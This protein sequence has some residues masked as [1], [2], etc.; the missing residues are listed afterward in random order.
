MSAPPSQPQRPT[1]DDPEA[2]RTYWKA[3]GMPWRMEPEISGIRKDDLEARRQGVRPDIER[4]LCVQRR[5]TKL[6]RADVEWLLETHESGGMRGPVDWT[7]V[8]L[9]K[10]EGLDLRGADSQGVNLSGLP[11]SFTI[12][13]LSL[14]DRP[15]DPSHFATQ[16]EDAAIHMGGANLRHTDLRQAYMRGAHLEHAHLR[17]AHLE[18]TRLQGAHLERAI[19]ERAWLTSDNNLEGIH[20]GSG[21]QGA[22]LVDVQWGGAN[23]TIA[24]WAQI[25]TLGDEWRASQARD[26][27]RRP[28]DE[29]RRLQEYIAAVRANRQI[30]DEPPARRALFGA[31]APSPVRRARPALILLLVAPYYQT[32][33]SLTVWASLTVWTGCA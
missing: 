2:W 25:K 3:Q 22:A 23:L 28:R 5:G 10:R 6:T 12:A 15:P 27:K 1:T 14:E 20:L 4:G 33:V 24:K 29:D 8:G 30:A 26:E 21:K 31:A 11:L 17:Y 9:K 19:L 13:G 16:I 32:H 7:S 18:G